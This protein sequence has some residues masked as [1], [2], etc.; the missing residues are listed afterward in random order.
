MLPLSSWKVPQGKGSGLFVFVILV[1]S[2]KPVRT[3]TNSLDS[4][5]VV[6]GLEANTLSF[7]L[8]TCL[9]RG[10]DFLPDLKPCCRVTGHLSGSSKMATDPLPSTY[11]LLPE[12]KGHF[13][14]RLAQEL[15]LLWLGIDGIIE[16]GK[17]SPKCRGADV[18]ESLSC[19][20]NFM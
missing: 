9:F 2:L 6:I 15:L 4:Y 13:V 20:E 7:L 3:E 5:P 17:R 10:T 1:R 18:C 11:L 8:P 14:E 19:S 16:L 12:R